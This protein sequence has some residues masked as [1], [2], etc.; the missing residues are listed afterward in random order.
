MAVS[1]CQAVKPAVVHDGPF[2]KAMTN[3]F[4]EFNTPLAA[5]SK[6]A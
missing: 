6:S 5:A 4:C 1:C 3:G 2:F